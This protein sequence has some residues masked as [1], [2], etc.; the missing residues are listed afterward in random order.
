ML[1][2]KSLAS[3]H[4]VPNVSTANGNTVCI[5]NHNKTIIINNSKVSRK[6]KFNH[7]VT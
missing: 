6:M 2:T 3:A 4:Q 7:C 5:D 1:F